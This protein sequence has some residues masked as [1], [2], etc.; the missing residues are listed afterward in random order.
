MN[1]AGTVPKLP[2]KVA[3]KKCHEG[4]KVAHKIGR[5]QGKVAH[6]KGVEC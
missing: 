4:I 6:K 5:W 2:L 1:T 3:H